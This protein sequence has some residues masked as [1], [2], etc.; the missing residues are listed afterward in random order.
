[1][2]R[3]HI[4]IDSWAIQ[5]CFAHQ[6]NETT[7][8]QVCRGTVLSKIFLEVMLSRLVIWLFHL[9]LWILYV[10]IFLLSC[11][12]FVFLEAVNNAASLSIAPNPYMLYGNKSCPFGGF[13]MK[14]PGSIGKCFLDMDVKKRLLIHSLVCTLEPCI[15]QSFFHPSSRLSF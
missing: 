8:L 5:E 2:R 15:L 3:K 1:M 7:Y 6:Y 11:K 9:S 12:V 14:C 4:A 13:Y 10:F